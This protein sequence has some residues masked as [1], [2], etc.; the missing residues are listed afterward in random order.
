MWRS[1]GSSAPASK[2]RSTQ[3]WVGVPAFPARVAKPRWR[4]SPA[5][6][7][8][9]ELPS[10]KRSTFP[11][12]CS[13][14]RE[15]G[16]G[17]G[18]ARRGK[19]RRAEALTMS[20]SC[21]AE[22]SAQPS[23][24]RAGREWSG[25]TCARG[26]A[27]PEEVAARAWQAGVL[28]GAAVTAHRV[29][30]PGVRVRNVPPAAAPAWTRVAKNKLQL[31]ACVCVCGGGGED[32]VAPLWPEVQKGHGPCRRCLASTR[33]THI[34]GTQAPGIR[35]QGGLR[36]IGTWLTHDAALVDVLPCVDEP[37]HAPP[38]QRLLHAGL[39]VW[40]C[41]WGGWVVIGVGGGG[42][43]QAIARR[44]SQAGPYGTHEEARG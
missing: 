44:H 12:H 18:T 36:V 40:G 16:A 30:T 15:T 42:R 24:E 13:P 14:L 38:H 7:K 29:A 17:C 31:C 6:A 8:G 2:T 34:P 39:R 41:V 4:N 19:G 35:K 11:A 1:G 32:E 20:G 27:G 26:R 9:V 43:L 23:C 33:G 3:A 25:L 10:G 37:P 21:G 28:A 5:V 22:A